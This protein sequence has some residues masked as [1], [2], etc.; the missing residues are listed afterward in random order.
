MCEGTV[1]S[2]YETMIALNLKLGR[3]VAEDPTCKDMSRQGRP[4]TNAEMNAFCQF[5]RHQAIAR[6]Q[7]NGCCESC[8][9]STEGFCW[10][11][12]GVCPRFSEARGMTSFVTAML[13]WLDERDSQSHKKVSE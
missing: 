5:H 13:A 12:K 11:I 3:E 2:S 1:E 4:L 7:K 10:D 6:T 8:T 9:P